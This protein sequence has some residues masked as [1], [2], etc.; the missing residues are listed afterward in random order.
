MKRITLSLLLLAFSVALV[1]ANGAGE[2][3]EAKKTIV[4][5]YTWESLENTNPIIAQFNAENPNIEVVLHVVPDNADTQTKL[6]VMMMGSSDIDVVQI[7]DGQQF[8]K[9]K[10]GLLRNIDDFIAKDNIDM[11]ANFGGTEAWAKFE[12]SYYCYPRHNSVGAV[13]YN[14]DMF[15]EMG[16]P[17]PADD[18]TYSEYA[19]L[20]KKL[21][22]GTGA[23]KVYGTFNH[24]RPGFW[25]LTALQKADFYTADGMANIGAAPFISDLKMRDYLDDNG[26]EKS[27]SDIMATNTLQNIEFFGKKTAMVQAASWLVRDMKNKEKYPYDFRVG[28]AY[29]PRFDETV[30]DKYTWG[31]VSALAIPSTSKN[32]EAAW[33]FIRYYIEKGSIQIAKA[34]TVP[35]YLPAYTDEMIAAFGEGSGLAAE[36]IQR[37]FDPELKSVMKMPVGEAM[38]EYNSII[39]E[40]TSLY[41]TKAKTLD[42]T[43][44]DMVTRVNKAI[45]AERA[46]K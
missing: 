19:E 6:D 37:F 33:K 29:F 28:V 24:I 21:T 30:Q 22:H 8:A 46:K 32:A 40:E 11:K 10:N 1:F 15:D 35:A 44:T 20:A 25:C 38:N 7:A 31:S 26:Y 43:V 12:G 4:N 2:T 14:K 23:D 5:Y 18:W 34:G 27:Y 13:F 39:Q 9:A 36:D 42:Q 17:Y 3:P 16:I 45:L 41:F